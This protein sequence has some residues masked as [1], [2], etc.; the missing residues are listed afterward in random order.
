[1]KIIIILVLLTTMSY[2]SGKR[3]FSKTGLEG[4]PMPNFKF[5]KT[6]DKSFIET[7]ED[8]KNKSSVLV[9]FLPSCPYCRL[10]I[11]DLI[12]HESKFKSTKLYLITYSSVPSLNSFIH[13][14]KL[15][16]Y[17]NITI[18]IDYSGSISRYYSIK[19]VPYLAIYNEKGNLIASGLGQTNSKDIISILY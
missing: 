8:S 2:C 4:S 16:N 19:G 13:E 14:F 1:M 10:T 6:T 18:G 12:R 9:Y 17:K 11:S 7:K 15:D 5:I 3:H